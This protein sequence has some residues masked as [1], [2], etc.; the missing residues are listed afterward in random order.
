ME[1]FCVLQ[2]VEYSAWCG[3][4]DVRFLGYFQNLLH[5]VD[6]SIKNNRFNLLQSGCPKSFKVLVNLNAELASWS[7]DQS[8]S[9]RNFL[10]FIGLA[11]IVQNW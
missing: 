4:Y 10:I 1:T 8:D 7:N 2:M 6:S 5:G 9:V 11:N 3:D